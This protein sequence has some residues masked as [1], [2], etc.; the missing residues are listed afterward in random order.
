MGFENK[1]TKASKPASPPWETVPGSILVGH[2]WTD[3]VLVIVAI[4]QGGVYQGAVQL[5]LDEARSFWTTLGQ[6]LD[7]LEAEA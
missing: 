2:S 5:P 4:R 1:A 3:P 6:L 7:T